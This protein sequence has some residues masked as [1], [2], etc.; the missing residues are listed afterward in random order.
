MAC[1]REQWVPDVWVGSPGL[2]NFS[3][4]I[5]AP[6]LDL[7]LLSGVIVQERGSGIQGSLGS[8]SSWA[9]LALCSETA[10]DRFG[11]TLGHLSIFIFPTDFWVEGLELPLPS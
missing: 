2:A 5:H 7:G 1:E 3:S 11:T 8:G 9:L 4:S 10:A 6:A